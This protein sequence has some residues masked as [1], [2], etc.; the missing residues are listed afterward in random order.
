[1]TEFRQGVGL[2]LDKRLT[3]SDKDKFYKKIADIAKTREKL[4]AK[5]ADKSRQNAVTR[6][7]KDASDFGKKL[8]QKG[9]LSAG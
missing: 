2:N 1:M 4:A 8:V 7:I 5:P 6:A 9:Q 3:M